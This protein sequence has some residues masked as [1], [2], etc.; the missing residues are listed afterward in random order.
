MAAA[1]ANLARRGVVNN[2]GMV[3]RRHALGGEIAAAAGEGQNAEDL[4]GVL[5]RARYA[6]ERAVGVTERMEVNRRGREGFRQVADGISATMQDADMLRWT[7]P[8]NMLAS[9]EQAVEALLTDMGHLFQEAAEAAE[10]PGRL[11]GLVE[12]RNIDTSLSTLR[13]RV[14]LRLVQFQGRMQVEQGA[15]RTGEAEKVLELLH[16]VLRE[17]GQ[18]T[19]DAIRAR[20]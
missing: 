2:G 19:D 16:L 11:H 5:G 13:E 15:A 9:T 10:P 14:T 6:L 8:T 1:F 4:G 7:A 12:P 3:F 17:A 20:G 18:R